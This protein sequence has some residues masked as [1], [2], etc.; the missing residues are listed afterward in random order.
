MSFY[1]NENLLS[2]GLKAET[3]SGTPETLTQ[4][5]FTGNW[6]AGL[7]SHKSETQT[8]KVGVGTTKLASGKEYG[9]LADISM[10]F[11]SGIEK[12]LIQSAGAVVTVDGASTHYDIGGSVYSGMPS[13]D[14][15]R[16]A[17]SS[18][19]INQYDG[20]EKLVLSGAKPS[21][22]KISG[23]AGEIVS[24]SAS[25]TGLFSKTNSSTTYFQVPAPESI[26]ILKGSA[27]E[28]GG[29]S[30]E[31]QDIEIDFKPTLKTIDDAS[32]VSG[33][34]GFEIVDIDPRITIS[35]YPGDA[36]IIALVKANT[37]LDFSW[38]IG[39]GV[40]NVFT[41]SGKVQIESHEA[42]YSDA[43]QIRKLVL[44]PV[45]TTEHNYQL[46][47]TNS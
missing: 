47:I 7:I 10:P 23:K 11:S 24:L 32:S 19:T 4:L 38:T 17:T 22:L 28:L 39:T 44:V 30:Y 15:G 46:R 42:S 34:A 26:N 6:K 12:D 20:K 27:L 43:L 2:T 36:D 5:E 18:I 21:S 29:V 41:F 45:Y 25:L 1:R 35:T 8:L 13:G 33:I 14:K 16:L 31:Y 9:E 37:V 40:G 3:T